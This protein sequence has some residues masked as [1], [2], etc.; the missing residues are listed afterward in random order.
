MR[1]I[2]LLCCCCLLGATSPSL[3]Q[4]PSAVTDIE[5]NY[6]EAAAKIIGTA[7]VDHGDFAK[8]E[9]LADR[10]GNRLSG[11]P[12]LDLAIQW[13]VTAMQADKLDRVATEPAKVPHWVR[14]N[15]SCD[16]LTPKKQK[17]TMLGLGNS[18]GTPAAGITAEVVAVHDF[19]E[20]KKLGDTVKGKIV[21]YSYAMRKDLE[22]DEAYGDAVKFRGQG[23]TAAA[24][25]GAVAVLIRSVTTRSLNTAHTGA[26][27]Y[28][29]EIPSIPAAALATEDADLLA[30]LCAAG[31]KPTVTLMMEAHM[32]PDVE[33]ANVIGE[34]RG[35]EKPDE[36]VVI[37]G[38][39]DS[40]DV[41]TGASDDGAGCVM[42]ME[43]ARIL[44][45][46]NLQPRR[47]IRV[48]LF[49]N[50]ENGLGGARAYAAAHKAEFDK[51]IAA[52]E[53]D[54]GAGRT[55]GFSF[56]GKGRSL[57]IVQ[58]IAALLK[59]IDAQRIRHEDRTGADISVLTSAGVPSFG[60]DSDRTHYFD[61][62]HTHADT[63]DK[64]NPNDLAQNTAALAVLAYILA[65]LP[66]PLPR[67]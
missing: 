61:V 40:W 2:A 49:T 63:L 54:S 23:P 42:A 52:V 62:H 15:E 20:L 1:L 39:I 43:A 65:D 25:Q 38:H 51:H 50:E 46:L 47:T 32:L 4:T 37:G 55:V 31:Q 30:R 17:L 58:Q 26:T 19:E 22:P 64:I 6:R 59:S 44:K 14:G 8:L 57:A 48:V 10:I 9:Y 21:L 53:C 35:R 29:A 27:R 41:G 3:A 28:T 11:S 34:I 12:Q 60:M 45:K 13:A 67:D 56:T 33:S 66:E 16:L 36:V 18:V 5:K 24:Q 7:M